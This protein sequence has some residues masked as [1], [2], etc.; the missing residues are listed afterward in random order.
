M[1][2]WWLSA[3][4]GVGGRLRF[5]LTICSFMMIFGC[6]TQKVTHAYKEDL[7]GRMRV[8]PPGHYRQSIDVFFSRTQAIRV[9]LN[10][11]LSAHSLTIKG[12]FQDL[13]REAFRIVED[14]EEKSAKLTIYQ[15]RFETY[16]DKIEMTYRKI[17]PLLFVGTDAGKG[18][19]KFEEYDRHGVPRFIKWNEGELKIGL[20]VDSYDLF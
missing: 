14:H 13:E 18:R 3:R 10:L 1:I 4:E 9:H 16:R 8:F 11:H 2:R 15:G 19:M 6:M 17:R 20:S 12:Y 7:A 5:G